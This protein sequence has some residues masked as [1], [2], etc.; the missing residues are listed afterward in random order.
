MR[1]IM[2]SV[3]KHTVSVIAAIA[4]VIM[5]AGSA[6]AAFTTGVVPNDGV[7][8]FTFGVDSVEEGFAVPASAVYD[9]QGTGYYTGETPTFSYGFLG[10]TENSYKTDV[11]S[12][13]KGVPHAIDG[14]KVVKGQKIVLKN[15]TDANGV[16]CVTGPAASEYLPEGA[17]SFEGRYPIRFSMRA[18]ERGYY[19][20]TCTV[21][22]ASSTAN[23]DVT[24]FSERC[25]TH[26]QHLVLEPG[27]TKMFAW[28]VELAPNVFKASGTYND[29]AINVVVVGENAALASVTVT[30]QPTTTENATVNGTA[31][32][33]INV[34]K[35]MWLCDD[36]TGTDQRCDT[37]Y[38]ALQNYAGVGS[39]LSRWAPADLSI[40]N[41]G[42]GGLASNDKAHFNSCL[43][44]PG[45][46][47]YVE[48]GHN[49]S[50]TESFTSNLEKYLT[51]A[52]E[53]DAYLIIVSPVERR[54]SWDSTNN[55]W[56]RTLQ[57]YA[58]AGKAWVEDKIANG[59]TNVVFLDLNEYYSTWMNEEIVRIHNV[60]SSVSLKDAIGFYYQC[61]KGG[62]VDS[63]HP[64]N[65]G[66]DWG[67]YWVWKAAV[68]AVAAGA[69]AQD[70]TSAQIQ[71]TVLA[72]ITDGVAAR[73]EADEPWL[74]SDDIINAGKAPNSYWDAT[75]R[76]GYD[77]INSAAVAAVDAA[78]SEGVATISGVSMRVLNQVN[79]AKAVIDIVS[80]DKA[81]TNRWYSFYNYDAS[82]N[83]SGD[84]VVPEAAGFL[85]ADLD[86]DVATTSSAEYS[87][88]LTVP[89]GGKAYIWFAEAN[90]NTW[91]VGENGPIS[92]VYPFEAWTQVLL[93]DDCSATSTWNSLFGGTKTFE[94]PDG[95]SYISFS[96]TGYNDSST[97]KAGGFAQ[98]FA[99]SA[100][101]PD[102]RI[103]VS[104][105][106]LYTRGALKFALS[107]TDGNSTSPMDGGDIIATLDGSAAVRGATANVTL[108]ADDT[109]V[110]Q[111]TIN[112]DEWMDVDM[113]IDLDAGK[114]LASIGG[115]DYE[116][117]SLG[118]LSKTPWG[119][120]GVTL[121][122]EKAHAGAI[123]D[124]KILA[125]SPSPTY[126]VEAAANNAKYGSVEINGAAGESIEAVEG[127]DVTLA[128]V[129]ADDTLY[130]FVRW[131]DA[132]GDTVSTKKTLFL[133]NV[134]AAA[135]YTAV[136]AAYDRNDDRTVTWDFSEY[137]ASPVSATAN[138]SVEYDGLT[139][140]L[141]NGDSVTAS[142]LVWVNS[143][144]SSSGSNLSANGKHIEFTP[145][146][147]GTLTLKFSID[148]YEDK[149]TP[150]MFIKAAES[151]SECSTANG[152]ITVYATVVD[153][154]YTLTANLTAGTK[155]YIWTYSY[156]WSGAKYYHNYTI[157]SIT[158]AY[159]PTW[160]TVSAT[161]AGNGSATVSAAEVVSGSTATF[162]AA[163]VSA[164]YTFTNWTDGEGSEVSTEATYT[165]TI[166]ADTALT[167][168]F[169]VVTDGTTL[170]QT[171]DFAALA[172]DTSIDTTAAWAQPYGFVEVHGAAGDTITDAGIYWAGPGGTK[173]DATTENTTRYIKFICAR[174]G[175]L[176]VK[177]YGTHAND[178]NNKSRMY[179]TDNT[180]VNG[181]I[182]VKDRTHVA[183]IDASS[184]NVE[185][186]VSASVTAGTTYYV[187]PYFYGQTSAAFYV[188]DISFSGG[189]KATTLTLAAGVN[190][191]VAINGTTGE[192]AYQV[193]KGEYVKLTAIPDA[194]YGLSSWTDGENNTLS[195][196]ETFWC[197]VGDA[198][199]VTANFLS[200]SLIDITR[201][202]DFTP[203]AGDDAITNTTAAWSQLVGRMEV[204][205]AAGDALTDGGVYWAGPG[206]TT[207]DTKVNN[208]GRY[209]KFECVKSGTVTLVY[210]SDTNTSK[211]HARMYATDGTES[212]VDCMYKTATHVANVDASAANSDTTLTF[213]AEAGK[214]YY[215]WPYFYSNASAKF[216]V[217]SI[218]W[219]TVKS[220]YSAVT[221][222]GASSLATTTNLYYGTSIAL[223]APATSGTQ[224]FTK[225]MSG[226]TELSAS[227]HLF[228]TATG[229]ATLT[230]VYRDADA[231]DFVWNP[232]VAS[233]DWNDSANWLYEGLVPAAT[234][235]SDSSQDVVAFDSIATVSF[236][237]NGM[238]SNV[239]FNA[240]A[241]LA[242]G[243]GITAK[244]VGGEGA[245]TL[246][247]SGFYN[248]SSATISN[249]LC[250]VEGTTNTISLSSG[251]NDICGDFTG[252]GT[253]KLIYPN[254]KEVDAWL[255]GDNNEYYG[256]VY[257]SGGSSSR[258]ALRFMH[259][260]SAGTNAYWHVAHSVDQ[261]DKS[262]SAMG[263]ASIGGY[264]GDWFDRN[265]G[266]VVTIGYLNR[267]SR[268]SIYN[269]VSGRANSI[270]KVG[271]ANLTLGTTKIKN[272]TVNG[273]AVTMPIG[274]APATL[275]IA[276]GAELRIPGD[277]EWTEGT[278]TNLFS[279]TTLAGTGA[280]SLASQVYVTGLTAG[281]GAEISV[282]NNTVKATIVTM[283]STDDV[284]SKV[285]KVSE[286]TFK[287][288]VE[289]EKVAL[290]IPENQTVSE[291]V[292][293][294]NTT[295]LTFSG[296]GTIA[297]NALKVAVSWTENEVLHTANY[298]IIKI[299]DNAVLLDA[300]KSVIVGSE[301]IPLTPT[302]T[303]SGDATPPLAVTS[304][305]VSLGVKTIP[306][307][308]YAVKAADNPAMTS[309]ASG[310]AIQATSA[311]TEVTAPAF[312]GNVKYYK[313]AVGITATELEQ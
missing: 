3:K 91:Q 269:S 148:S 172:A 189:T 235:P 88:T 10:T 308:W 229:E 218:S 313:V 27:E 77:Y 149:R 176:S 139:I 202:C 32:T 270:T 34:G 125:L 120:F 76:A 182:M 279:Y 205:G 16:S 180:E 245:I 72:G 17:S 194:Y 128:A 312:S 112:S 284:E 41:Q 257:T 145:A 162:T 164:A 115:S 117:Y 154:E 236:P 89:A 288:K 300:T 131:K 143:A 130:K 137:A 63:A 20:V 33:S 69:D 152:D 249:N 226:E 276:D 86:K 103:R 186:T 255:Y 146:A 287:V 22:N 185:T 170:A 151:S 107:S 127:S 93:D 166:T 160:C 50:S 213:A 90:G 195:T 68:D 35:T 124:V 238:A 304:D 118:A 259:S 305:D 19:A 277:A 94:V 85:S 61:S 101:V 11:P 293:S 140:Y 286:N 58:T 175:T 216:W 181:K 309:A 25:H 266:V 67:A 9:V 215:I 8:K 203:F 214:T 43:L 283:P 95:E 252:F 98:A 311:T 100:T 51:R 258:N 52:N 274:I 46:Y 5:S 289:N 250:F 84:I 165:A 119:Y 206:T 54:Y 78:V 163:P 187:W 106:T 12:N 224:I 196:E 190:G 306:G 267:D 310:T 192:G 167:A 198:M 38:F 253:L 75:V 116:S 240:D 298:Q 296:T 178:G 219:T 147:S 193:Q 168:N 278:E 6:F 237:A 174:S 29:N 1:S 260:N 227:T 261:N 233:G 246:D 158:Y 301:E 66:A 243:N 92:A 49:E 209:I 225:W 129:C 79:Y 292:V 256:D 23:A 113:I 123:D 31:Q 110:A 221:V 24:L 275:T 303:D 281:L 212:G 232:A 159:T 199:T 30:K 26:A 307:L 294:P 171:I 97:K 87:E 204:Y 65:A 272:L 37:P 141:N 21:A 230:A 40:R 102:G 114:V 239:W 156:N 64:N 210:H 241:T 201:S 220:D 82:G 268:I 188:T 121:A 231:H 183:N 191:N 280:G 251:V 62:K 262:E 302:P 207:S 248:L 161:S 132:N 247:N 122:S 282:E 134:E 59:A 74:V 285:T 48:Y 179:I 200:E 14:F 7:Y 99:D 177:Y 104:F 80:S 242:G 155:Y 136:F 15:A 290:T 217:S 263:T 126:L 157:S 264:D 133:E 291:I 173:S 28:S 273:G 111:S 56:N 39:G 109:P 254:A 299:V 4:A 42:E 57:S 142:G 44:K 228:Y 222:E 2:C 169:A 153:T 55:Q 53:A 197:Y 96:M 138:T 297:E 60:N 105:K 244:M 36:S 18:D 234:Y 83:T 295:N 265:D 184:P 73:L 70:G 108:S 13:L 135:S 144:L 223:D 271:T 81:T 71:A 45:D 211:N 150:T 47:L 208:S